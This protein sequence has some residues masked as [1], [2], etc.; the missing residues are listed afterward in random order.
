MLTG[1]ILLSVYFLGKGQ[2][3]RVSWHGTAC[4]LQ[5]SPMKYFKTCRNCTNKHEDD[6]CWLYRPLTEEGRV[7]W[8]QSSLCSWGRAWGVTDRGGPGQ[9]WTR[10]PRT[11]YLWVL[12]PWYVSA[13]GRSSPYFGPRLLA[14]PSHC[15]HSSDFITHPISKGLCSQDQSQGKRLDAFLRSF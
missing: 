3:D 10:S 6:L 4:P 11:L 9:S 2:L 15:S 1:F 13:F 7:M 12:S 5:C 8:L 14:V